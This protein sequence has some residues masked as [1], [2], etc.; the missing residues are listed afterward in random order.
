[1]SGPA[2]FTPALPKGGRDTAGGK[3][4]VLLPSDPSD[5]PFPECVP[6][7]RVPAG[8]SKV[9]ATGNGSDFPSLT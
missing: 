3:Y 1:M 5:E 4:A 6:R 9:R 8:G 7:N 2:Q